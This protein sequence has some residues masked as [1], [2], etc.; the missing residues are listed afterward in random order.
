MFCQNQ[1][2][3]N[4]SDRRVQNKDKVHW[5]KTATIFKPTEE[6]MLTF[7]SF[8]ERMRSRALI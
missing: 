8:P 4:G 2:P 6:N 7:K 1:N 5:R 3:T